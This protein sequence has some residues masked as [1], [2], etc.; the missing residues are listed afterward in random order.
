MRVATLTI[1][2]VAVTLVSGCGGRTDS[3]VDVATDSSWITPYLAEE[4]PSEPR[5]GLIIESVSLQRPVGRPAIVTVVGTHPASAE[6]TIVNAWEIVRDGSIGPFRSVSLDVSGNFE[7]S[8]EFP[9]EVAGNDW[10]PYDVALIGG[11]PLFLDIEQ[12]R[13]AIEDGGAWSQMLSE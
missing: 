7:T 5:P 3:R 9:R 2:L 13:W 1:L 6:T 10:A 4:L 8:F 11:S 12:A